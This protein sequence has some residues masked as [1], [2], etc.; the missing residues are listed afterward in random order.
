MIKRRFEPAFFEGK[1]AVVGAS[2]PTLQDVHPTPFGGRL[3][4]G[5]EVQANAVATVLDGIP[6]RSSP[7]C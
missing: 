5:A 3:M 7:G 2:A 6:L 4:S 1:V